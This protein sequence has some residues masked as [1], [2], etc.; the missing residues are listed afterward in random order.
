MKRSFFIGLIVLICLSSVSADNSLNKAGIEINLPSGILSLY[1]EGNFAKEYPLCLGKKST[2]TPAGQYRI[3]YKAVN[4]HWLNKGVV[5]SPGPKNPL[6]IRWMGITRGIGIH[7]NNKPE[8]I[9]TY[10][11]AGC[12][13]MFNRDVI[14]VYNQV[15]VNTPVNIKYDRLKLF[16]DKYSKKEGIFIYPDIYKRGVKIAGQQLAQL[17]Q[18]DI[19]EELL[20]KAQE[21]IAKPITK[22]IMVSDGIGVFLNNSIITCDAFGE[23]GEIYMNCKAAEDILGLTPELVSQYNIGIKELNGVIYINLMQTVNSFGGTVSH[24]EDIGNVYIDMEVVKINGTFA[25][26]NYGD[27][28]KSDFLTVEAV[29]QLGY[30]FTE[31]SVDIRI[32][33]KGVMKLKRKDEW[34]ID[35]DNLTEILGG[36]KDASSRCGIVDIKLPA[37]LRIGEE[38]FKVDNVNGRLVLNA[39]TAQMIYERSGQVIEAYSAIEQSMGNNIDLMTFLEDYDYSANIFSTVI[40]IKLKDNQI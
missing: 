14:E 32:F 15:T 12:I 26:I 33:D 21:I 8:S 23:E 11:S 13:R 35:A 29:K 6:G 31:D 5:V 24:N 7:G 30:E 19:S 38:Y 22:T 2:P 40:D 4:P 36:S 16:R 37:Y 17:S 25:G 27:Y 20:K 18:E 39:E 1:K 34:V 9:G 3:I 10:A 28:D